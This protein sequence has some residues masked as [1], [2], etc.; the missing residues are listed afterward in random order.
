MVSETMVA[1]LHAMAHS[2]PSLFLLLLAALWQRNRIVVEWS[3]AAGT[4]L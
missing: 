1:D 3:L 2:D 4:H